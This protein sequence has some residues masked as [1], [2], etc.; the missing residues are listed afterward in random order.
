[1]LENSGYFLKRKPHH[2]AV[3]VAIPI[4]DGWFTHK[5]PNM[6]M[7]IWLSPYHVKYFVISMEFMVL[8]APKRFWR[9]LPEIVF[10]SLSF[11]NPNHLKT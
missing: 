5:S 2:S 8:N 10:F 11:L 9:S 6:W 4:Q 3:V 7:C 1:M